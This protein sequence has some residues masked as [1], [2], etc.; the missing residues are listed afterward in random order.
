MVTDKERAGKIANILGHTVAEW[1]NWD[2]Y[3]KDITREL[4]AVRKECD[5]LWRKKVAEIQKINAE[6]S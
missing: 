1:R 3:I 2:S 4:E 5:D 6:D